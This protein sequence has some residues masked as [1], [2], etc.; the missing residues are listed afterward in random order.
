MVDGS[1][2]KSRK[3]QNIMSGVPGSLL[4]QYVEIVL[5]NSYVD[6][7]ICSSSTVHCA[8]YWRFEENIF[9]SQNKNDTS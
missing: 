7:R 8:L 3:M 4:V 9:F 2:S 6:Y 5:S 1:E